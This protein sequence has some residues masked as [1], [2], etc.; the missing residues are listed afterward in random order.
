MKNLLVFSIDNKYVEPFIVAIKSFSLTHDVNKYTVGLLYSNIS[1]RNIKK[2]ESFFY[3]ID[4]KIEIIKIEDV[5]TGFE[6]K[7]HFNSVIFYRF[8]I[9]E[10]FKNYEKSIYIDSDMVFLGNI[11]L[12]FE[13]DLEGY[14]VGAVS[15]GNKFDV[16][17]HMKHVTSTYFASGLLLINH[18]NFKC[19]KIYEKCIYFLKNFNYE[20][21]DQDAL[22]YAI[23]DKCVYWISSDFG[24][25]THQENFNKDELDDVNILQ[26]SG[27]QKPW[28]CGNEH[29]CRDIYLEIWS[30]TPLYNYRFLFK[31]YSFRKLKEIKKRI[32]NV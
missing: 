3:S 10:V 12:L 16:P 31:D 26:F 14:I 15:R 8:L 1:F 27:G 20:M 25:L 18:K 7:Y 13:I 11:D 29:P 5:F 4:L 30:K 2:I 23:K 28:H 32:Y 6:I 21:P 22:N 17:L 19:E 24:V 9:P